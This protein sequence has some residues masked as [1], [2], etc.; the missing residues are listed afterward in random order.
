MKKPFI[1]NK[2]I[3]LKICFQLNKVLN[4]KKYFGEFDFFI[5]INN[6]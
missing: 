2:M 6:Y 1:M 3:T 4:D 5:I